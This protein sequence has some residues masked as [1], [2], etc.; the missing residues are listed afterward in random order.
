MKNNTQIYKHDF[1]DQVCNIEE[2]RNISYSRIGDRL[3]FRT[4]KTETFLTEKTETP[5]PIN[6]F[7]V[8]IPAK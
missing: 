6:F 5:N 7:K 2:K 3:L 8:R 4:E 1:T